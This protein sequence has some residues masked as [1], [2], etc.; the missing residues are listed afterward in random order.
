MTHEQ[1]L[2]YIQA[3]LKELN[4]RVELLLKENQE[5]KQREMDYLKKYLLDN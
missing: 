1:Q 3:Q 5:L 2:K 4:D